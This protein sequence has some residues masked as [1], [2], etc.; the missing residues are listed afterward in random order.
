MKTDVYSISGEKIREIELPPIFEEEYRPDIINRA[1]SV[2]RANRR[3]PYGPS[4][5]A[6]MRHSVE[7][8]GKG[9]G[10]ARVQRV[11]GDRRAAQSPNNVGGRRSHPPRPEHSWKEK[12]NK[13]EI[14][15]AL[16][17]A[18]AATADR[19]TVSGR[20]HRFRDDLAMPIVVEDALEDFETLVREKAEREGYDTFKFTQELLELAEN[21]GIDT[22]LRRAGN[23]MKIRAGRGK[24]RGRKYRSPKSVL[25]VVSRKEA[26]ERAARNLTG[27]EVV[28]ARELNVE[29]LA[30]GGDP[31][32]LT[33]FTEKALGEMEGL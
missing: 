33:I 6:G 18:L 13:K 29:H 2:I 19:E 16:R 20:G 1:V 3:Q 14:A 21:I 27:V 7:T 25:I 8:W 26:I 12:M 22:D 32:R 30:P 15:K 11:T 4:P 28:T 10:V 5:M 31:G 9:R 23:G 24:M 17:S